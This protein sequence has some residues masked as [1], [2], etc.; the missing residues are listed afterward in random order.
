MCDFILSGGRLTCPSTLHPHV[1]S[2]IESYWIDNVDSRPPCSNAV[3]ILNKL[4]NDEPELL[5]GPLSPRID[6]TDHCPPEILGSQANQYLIGWVGVAERE[7]AEAKLKG[8][9]EGTFLTRYSPKR[10]C[11]VVSFIKK[12]SDLNDFGHISG[13][14]WHPQRGMLII[15]SKDGEISE[16]FKDLKDYVNKQKEKGRIEK[17]VLHSILETYNLS[18]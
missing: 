6:R 10:K 15:L 11:F 14:Q 12:S 16:E 4:Y 18:E 9:A 17:S 7:E 13:P 8:K 5:S 1:S 2:L 3:P